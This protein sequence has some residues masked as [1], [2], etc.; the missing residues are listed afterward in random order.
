[1]DANVGVVLGGASGELQYR[2]AASVAVAQKVTAVVELIGRRIDD[3]GRIIAAEAPHPSLID[4]NTTRLIA[5]PGVQH[6]AAMLGGVKWNP[7]GTW[8]LSASVSRNVGDRGLRSGVVAQA[9]LDYAW[10]R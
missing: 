9:G 10:T 3:F 2:G 6:T 1:L 5:E 7:A 8:L 4:V